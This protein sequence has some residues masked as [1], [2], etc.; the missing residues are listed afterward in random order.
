[1]QT[2][3]PD[4]WLAPAAYGSPEQC[5]AA[6]NHQLDL[7]CDGVIL[8]GASPKELEPIVAAYA[9]QRD[10]YRFKNLPANPALAPATVS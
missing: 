6:I 9:D 2:L 1:M 4:E 10:H 8:H 7:G 3:I 5:V